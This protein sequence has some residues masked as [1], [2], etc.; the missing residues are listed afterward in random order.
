MNKSKSRNSDMKL[1]DNTGD[2]SND[3][4]IFIDPD[5]SMVQKTLLNEENS[6]SKIEKLSIADCQKEQQGF[7]NNLIISSPFFPNT[8][9]EKKDSLKQIK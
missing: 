7:N 1:M 3:V 4:S 8:N 6:E 5:V 2:R 9:K